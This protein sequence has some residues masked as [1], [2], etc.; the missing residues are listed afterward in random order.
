MKQHV[1]LKDID[2]QAVIE[3]K[4][5]PTFIPEPRPPLTR[6]QA[7]DKEMQQ[8]DAQQIIREK[9]E[10]RLLLRRNS[11]Q[12]LFNGYDFDVEQIRH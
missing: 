2:W 6:L 11:V 5:K 10:G 8:A 12:N 3:M 4:V 7:M 9:E 1:W